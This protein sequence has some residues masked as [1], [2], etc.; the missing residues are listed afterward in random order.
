[1]VTTKQFWGSV[2]GSWKNEE[3]ELLWFLIIQK[4]LVL[5]KHEQGVVGIIFGHHTINEI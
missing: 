2:R 4:I 3:L 5:H 1:M